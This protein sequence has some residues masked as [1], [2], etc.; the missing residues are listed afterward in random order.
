M[1]STPQITH[2]NCF[3]EFS[4]GLGKGRINKIRIKYLELTHHVLL[5]FNQTLAKT[6]DQKCLTALVILIKNFRAQ[7]MIVTLRRR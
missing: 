4:I 1:Y 6:T 2:L 7:T 5:I 3:N